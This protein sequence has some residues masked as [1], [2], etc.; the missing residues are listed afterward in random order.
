MKYCEAA[1]KVCPNEA[2]VDAWGAH[3]G[4]LRVI[5]LCWP[6]KVAVERAFMAVVFVDRRTGLIL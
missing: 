6:C 5:V 4:G 1:N 2:L 3:D